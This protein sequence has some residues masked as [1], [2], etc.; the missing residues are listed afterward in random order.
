MFL[1]PHTRKKNGAVYEY[2]TL[3]ESVRTQDGPRQRTVATLG[4]SPG[5]DE[6][7]RVGWK[8]IRNV[9]DGRVAQGDLFRS[10]P[11]SP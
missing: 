8:H 9:L 2:W 4:K 1:R 11:A 3:E 6:E 5:L 10:E 7:A